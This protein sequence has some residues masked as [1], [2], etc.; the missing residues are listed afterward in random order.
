MAAAMPSSMTVPTGIF[1]VDRSIEHF[2]GD[3]EPLRNLGKVVREAFVVLV[4]CLTMLHVRR[5]PGTAPS[6]PAAKT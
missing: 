4:M 5:F 3:D 1:C 2:L 6:A